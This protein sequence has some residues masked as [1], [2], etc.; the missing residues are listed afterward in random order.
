MAT[1]E[2]PDPRNFIE[3]TLKV[4]A[5][6]IDDEIEF[7]L[8]LNPNVTQ[9]AI[10]HSFSTLPELE[11]IFRDVLE[12]LSNIDQRTE[13]YNETIKITDRFDK[14]FYPEYRQNVQPEFG[15]IDKVVFNRNS[16]AKSTVSYAKSYNGDKRP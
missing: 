9:I 3:F 10:E 14:I 12:S 13:L 1:S 5:S 15:K 4:K 16:P 8:D 11:R 7:S 2:K 6:R